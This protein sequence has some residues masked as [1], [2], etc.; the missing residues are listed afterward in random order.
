MNGTT[1]LL[2]FDAETL[3]SALRTV[4]THWTVVE[5]KFVMLDYTSSECTG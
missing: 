2:D 3:T 1:G 4:Y 5:G